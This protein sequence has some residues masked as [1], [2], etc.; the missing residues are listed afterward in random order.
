MKKIM[1]YTLVFGLSLF[2]ADKLSAQPH[3]AQQQSGAS[4]GGSSINGT[5]ASTPVGE[6]AGLLIVFSVAYA[7]SRY[8]K[9]VEE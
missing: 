1:I 9:K 3:P 5:S 7:V 8:R 6:G 2:A 4:T